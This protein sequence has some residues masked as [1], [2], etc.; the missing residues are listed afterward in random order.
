MGRNEKHRQRAA[1]RHRKRRERKGHSAV[2]DTLRSLQRKQLLIYNARQLPIHECLVNPSWETFGL[3]NLLIARRMPDDRLV[4]GQYLVD[5]YCL[6][7]KNTCCSAYCPMSVYE[8]KV[9]PGAFI[10]EKPIQCSRLLFHQII[11]GAIEYAGRIGFS[12]H[13]NFELS[14]YILDP[15]E[16]IPPNPELV[17]G[18]DGK[19]CYVSGPYDDVWVIIRT[20]DERVGR[21]NYH[22]IIGGQVGGDLSSPRRPCK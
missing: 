1:E 3:A 21:G 12:P 14:Q 7:L 20:L 13:E 17:F 11:Y 10:S 9:K 6:G 4:L 22:Y 5:L 18:F 2:V 16:T 19:P 8:T 15:P